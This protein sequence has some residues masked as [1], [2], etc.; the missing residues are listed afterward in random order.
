M[1]VGQL[2]GQIVAFTSRHPLLE[3]LLVASVELVVVTAV[4]LAIIHVARV[5]SNRVVALLWLVALAKPVMSL[6][7]GTPAPVWNAGS[8]AVVPAA[9]LVTESTDMTAHA[10]AIT[11]T[12]TGSRSAVAA[13]IGSASAP[14]V[15]PS[16]EPA[17]VAA[18]MWLLGVGFMMMLSM[19]DR[20]RIRKLVASASAPAPEI[21]AMYREVSGTTGKKPRLLISDR[22]ES[23]AIAGTLFPVVLLPAWMANDTDRERVVWSLRHE[24]THWRHRDH[25]AGFVAELSRIL[26]FF[27]PL[28]WWI[29]RKWKVATEIACDQAMV[30]TNR[31]ARRYAEQ[32]YQIL[33]RVHTR[34]RIMLANGLFATRTQI[35]RRIELL[36][37]SRPCDRRGRRVPAVV[38]LMV[39]CALAFSLGAELSPQADPG[40]I[41]ITSSGKDGERIVATLH[42]GDEDGRHVVLT[43]KGEVEFNDDRTDI[44]RISPEGRFTIAEVRD[45]VE[46]ELTIEADGDEL[47]YDYEV[48]GESRPFD[49]EARRWFRLMLKKIHVD[50]SGVLGVPKP[51]VI[52]RKP[53]VVGKAGDSRVKVLV[54]EPG[55]TIDIYY[56][57]DSEATVNI[58]M[59]EDDDEA[60]VWISTSAKIVGKSGDRAVLRVAPG[61]EVRIAIEQDGDTH[62]LIVPAGER[63]E[64]E[65]VYKLNGE[66]RPYDDDASKIFA[67]YM[68]ILEDGLEL[69]VKGE[70]I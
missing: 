57:D 59:D 6:V 21:E 70:K 50:D 14:V 15:W 1:N 37:N 16:A 39:F 62:E 55:E 12:I 17:D 61:G 33:A 51:H 31:D 66:V 24:L 53:L 35:G 5:R 38:F 28:V 68:K 46:R 67:P 69:N 49:D 44:V 13:A 25:L 42:E 58:M 19:A 48:D 56:D 23:P 22:L 32:L 27:H 40:D 63:D 8:L 52:L 29:G 41:V 7:A 18:T 4:V 60:K 64:K 26:F 45:G 3:R 43:I 30:S 11:E 65:F 54:S 47:N 20:L 9:S 2:L 34:R 36:L 10:T